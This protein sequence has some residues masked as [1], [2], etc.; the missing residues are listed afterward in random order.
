[1]PL[2]DLKP[3]PFATDALAP[4]M[5]TGTV[6]VHHDVH[7]AAYVHRWNEIIAKGKHDFGDCENLAFNGAG[8]VLHELFWNNL[9]SL[10]NGTQPSPE[11]QSCLVRCFGSPNDMAAQMTALGKQIW[12]SGWVV[13]VWSPRFDR[14][15]TLPINLHQYGWIPG[16][17]P[18]LVIDCFEHAYEC[19]YVGNRGTYLDQIWHIINWDAVNYRYA[20]ATKAS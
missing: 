2:E 10:N 5:N 7:Q 18:L 8:I 3:L 4:M 19:Q 16:A 12:G 20:E 14:M 9:A 1:M 6:E 11:L 13:L 15:L 17:V